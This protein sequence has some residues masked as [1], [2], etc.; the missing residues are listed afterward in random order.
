MAWAQAT[1][2]ISNLPSSPQ[3]PK[4]HTSN[5]APIPLW[6]LIHSALPNQFTFTYCILVLTPLS[7]LS[8][9]TVCSYTAPLSPF[10]ASLFI[11]L[12]SQ[13]F[14]LSISS[15]SLIQAASPTHANCSSSPCRSPTAAEK[16]Q[17]HMKQVPC[18]ALLSSSACTKKAQN[19]NSRS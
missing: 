4:P 17:E 7:H 13:Y 6:F 8:V 12:T 19:C 18:I 3:C 11:L 10:P 9:L 15:L 1:S 2:L 16:H 5:S 14:S